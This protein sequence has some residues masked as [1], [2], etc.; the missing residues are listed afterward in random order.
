MTALALSLQR[1]L[2]AQFVHKEGDSSFP[3]ISK[4]LSSHPL[5]RDSGLRPVTDKVFLIIIFQ[6]IK[7]NMRL[8]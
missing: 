5:L 6:F 1:L 8:T 4:S 2:L 7:M 3:L